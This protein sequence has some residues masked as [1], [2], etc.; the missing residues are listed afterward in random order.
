MSSAAPGGSFDVAEVVKSARRLS[1]PDARNGTTPSN[2]EAQRREAEHLFEQASPFRQVG[3]AVRDHGWRS[4]AVIAAPLLFAWTAPIFVFVPLLVACTAVGI[5]FQRQKLEARADEAKS[6]RAH[7]LSLQRDQDK[8]RSTEELDAQQQAV[9]SQVKVANWIKLGSNLNRG[10]AWA[11]LVGA[12]A[13]A[14]ASPVAGLVVF[15]TFLTAR[16]VNLQVNRA[17]AGYHDFLEKRSSD[18]TSTVRLRAERNREGDRTLDDFRSALGRGLRLGNDAVQQ[19]LSDIVDSVLGDDVGTST[20]QPDQLRE[21]ARLVARDSASEGSPL[22]QVAGRGR[23][24]GW[25][26]GCNRDRSSDGTGIS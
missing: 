9:S 3:R 18:L 1:S 26:F 19:R 21:I 15:G 23:G 4:A 25:G 16:A 12:G 5:R 8:N 2:R 6:Q 24:R 20:A 11:A 17:S 13:L 14:V 10:L 7:A 22:N